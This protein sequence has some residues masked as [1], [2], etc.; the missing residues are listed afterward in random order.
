MTKPKGT[1]SA[2]PWKGDPLL[3]Y[4]ASYHHETTSKVDK[5][6]TFPCMLLLHTRGN[7]CVFCACLCHIVYPGPKPGT[8]PSPQFRWGEV[9]PP[10]WASQLC[11]ND[12][13]CPGRQKCCQAWRIMMTDCF[14]CMDPLGLPQVSLT[15]NL[16]LTTTTKPVVKPTSKFVSSF[17]ISAYILCGLS[18]LS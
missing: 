5:L 13:Q 16:L 4:Q 18:Q 17:H 15:R 11:S 9:C 10:P 6:S 8:C 2:L 14:A 3:W 7:E 12:S 1:I